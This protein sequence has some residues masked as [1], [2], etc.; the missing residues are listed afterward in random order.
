MIDLRES[1]ATGI[2]QTFFHVG[3]HY[4]RKGQIPIEHTAFPLEFETNFEIPT[5]VI[6]SRYLESSPDVQR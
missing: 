4:S 3:D 1:K 5:E 6:S 2:H